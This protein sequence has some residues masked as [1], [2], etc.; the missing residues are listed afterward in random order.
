MLFRSSNGF[1]RLE[2]DNELIQGTRLEVGYEI[3][4]TNIS[5]MDYKSEK[6]Y[7]YGILEGDVITIS[8]T[9]IIDYLDNN[10][11]F[12]E[13]ENPEYKWEVKSA[14]DIK[15]LVVEEVYNRPEST[16]GDKIILYTNSLANNNIQ[17][18]KSETIML[19]VSRRLTTTDEISFGNEAEIVELTRPGG[20]IPESTPG[21]YVPGTTLKEADESMAETTIV[22]PATGENRNYMLPIVIGATAL[23]ILGVGVIII[24]KK[25]I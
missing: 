24:K 11:S 12:E 25:V 6:F 4:A 13:K 10:W 17:P 22:T 18:E 14:E 8:P 20:S 23:I 9:G 16:I 7:Q 3:K 2:M 21:N 5:E 15:V 1:I 19:N